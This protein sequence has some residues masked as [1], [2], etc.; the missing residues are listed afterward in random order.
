M[1]TR[2]P[3]ENAVVIGLRARG[4]D[5]LTTVEVGRTGTT[6]P[7]QLAFAVLQA[8]TIYT[9]N[10]GDFA[11]LHSEYLQNGRSIGL[12]YAFRRR[13]YVFDLRYDESRPE[14]VR[15]NQLDQAPRRTKSF[16]RVAFDVVRAR[17]H[18]QHTPTFLQV[19]LMQRYT[20]A[21]GISP[22]DEYPAR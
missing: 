16:L 19:D 12:A 7:E 22:D 6:D 3:R 4:V 13:A 15:V 9:F 5:L 11:Q 17:L 18:G 14:F 8:R 1:W 20:P 21:I 10:V 2:T